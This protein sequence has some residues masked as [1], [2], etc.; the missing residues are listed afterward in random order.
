MSSIDL[1]SLLPKVMQSDFWAEF[2]DCVDTE[3]E[4]FKSDKCTPKQNILNA[5][6]LSTV[7]DLQKITTMFGYYPDTTI[8]GSVD[9]FKEEINSI[10]FRIKRKTTYPAYDY[11]F[12][13]VPIT[14]YVYN[15][16]WDDIALVKAWDETEIETYLAAH[17]FSQPFIYTIPEYY[18]SFFIDDPFALDEGH[19]LD[20]GLYL[21]T[22]VF[23]E[24][25][26]HLAIEIVPITLAFTVDS[27]EP[28]LMTD[29]YLDYIQHYVNYNRKVTEVPHVGVQLNLITDTSRY[30]NNLNGG[31]S[32]TVPDLRANL[33]VNQNWVY[34]TKEES[35]GYISAGVGTNQ[36][37]G[38]GETPGNINSLDEE[39][40][41]RRLSDNEIDDTGSYYKVNTYIPLGTV[42]N[43]V[44]FV[45][46]GVTYQRSGF[47]KFPNVKE[48]SFSI[49]YH[50]NNEEQTVIDDGLGEL[51]SDVFIGSIDYETGEFELN[52]VNAASE[53]DSIVPSGNPS[54]ISG[55]LSYNTVQLN[56]V[57]IA[58][59]YGGNNYI[60]RS[61]ATGTITGNFIT[62][63]TVT[64]EGVISV[65]WI[66][67][68][69]SSA[70]VISYDYDNF[71][72]PTNGYPVYIN[73]RT[74]EVVRIREIGIKDPNG[75][76]IAY[77]T[78]PAVHCADRD[79]HLSLN[80]FI[81]KP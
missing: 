63:G 22:N 62:S 66:V 80:L 69:T 21:D 40:Y 61:D 81:K 77:G 67:Q 57:E 78:V 71:G 1:T 59:A 14:G 33:A 27:T 34:T 54:T 44:L 17:D 47:T 13:T 35:I 5:R 45:G 79:F 24:T 29:D 60:G 19:T 8:N 25:T 73:Y 58:Y 31:L 49:T 11:I 32:Y 75:V 18:Y 6:E 4:L 39:I 55:N 15:I 20:D 9:F 30:Y 28:Y 74:E 38:I 37:W 42:K 43:L 23:Q 2:L 53:D 26:H 36:M 41:E 56:T 50:A 10:A 16:F 68:I 12:K 48:K 72:I 51:E 70:V 7:T 52:F 3:L 46:D 65:T 64:R 76:L